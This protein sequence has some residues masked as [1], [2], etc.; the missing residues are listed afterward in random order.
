MGAEGRCE[1]GREMFLFYPPVAVA[2]RLERLGGLRQ[3]L[4]DR[5]TALTFIERECGNIDKRRDTWM[6]PGL[7]DDGPAITV[8]YQNHWPVHGVDGRLRILLVLGVGS[9]GV[10]RHRHLVPVVHEDFGDGFPTRAVGESS[11]HQDNVVD[12]LC[13]DHSP[14]L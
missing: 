2:V 11:M 5:R 7:G 3:G 10:L 12:T 13:H 6:I 9:L 4:F 14:L 8:P 1:I